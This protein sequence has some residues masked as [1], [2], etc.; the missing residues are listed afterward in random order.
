[1][2]D[3]EQP[4]S[5]RI[6]RI[7]VDNAQQPTVFEAESLLRRRSEPFDLGA[8][9]VHRDATQTHGLERLVSYA[10]ATLLA[11]FTAFDPE[12]CA[13]CVMVFDDGRHGGLEH[14]DV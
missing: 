1:M 13:Q 12:P 3:Q 8:L 5:T 7:E 10:V 2:D 11:P 9:L 14:F 4:P 6:A